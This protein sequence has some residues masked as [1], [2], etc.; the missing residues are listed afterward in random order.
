MNCIITNKSAE[1]SGHVNVISI[2]I[3]TLTNKYIIKEINGELQISKDGNMPIIISIIDD[4][5]SL[6]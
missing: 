2:N 3:T 6:K 1:S 5:I 4:F